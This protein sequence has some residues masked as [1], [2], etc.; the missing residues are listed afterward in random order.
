M[1]IRDR[2]AA[3]RLFAFE[4][5]GKCQ[6]PRVLAE[7]RRALHA[8]RQPGAG[9]RTHITSAMRILS[10]QTVFQGAGWTASA[11]HCTMRAANSGRRSVSAALA[12]GPSSTHSVHLTPSLLAAAELKALSCESTFIQ[13]FI[14]VIF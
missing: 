9:N 2:P 11:A 6:E 3:P 13:G 8:H 7:R 4:P 1:C 10:P 14:N 5:R 12:R